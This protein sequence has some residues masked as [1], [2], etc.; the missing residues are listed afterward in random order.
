M[1]PI[2]HI[3]DGDKLNCATGV[4]INNGRCTKKGPVIICINF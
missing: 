1:R 4:L 2:G 3:I